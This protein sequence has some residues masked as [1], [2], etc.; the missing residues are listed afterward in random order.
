MMRRLTYRAC[1]QARTAAAACALVVVVLAPAHAAQ[2]LS[3][4]VDLVSGPR[5]AVIPG[6]VSEGVVYF[7]PEAGGAPG[8]P[9]RYSVD[10]RTKGFSPATLVVPANSVIAFPNR[11]QILH[12]VYSKSP[13]AEFDLGTYGPGEVREARLPRAG[14][15][16]VNC[17]VHQGMRATVLVLDTPYYTRPL[18]DGRFDLSGLP[19]GN[20]TLVFWHPRARA[21][22]RPVAGT[23]ADYAVQLRALRPRVGAAGGRP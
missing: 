12:N 8:R 20:G 7:L 16:Q 2:R 17:N 9:G 15:V 3:G 14:L 4:R 13:A 5:Q 23:R 22:S 18:A 1:R 10:T 11:D 19:D 6:E 21:E